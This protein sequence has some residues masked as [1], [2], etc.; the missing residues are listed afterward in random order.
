MWENNRQRNIIVNLVLAILLVVVVTVLTFGILK[1]NRETAEHDGQLSEIYVQQQQE[2]NEARQENLTAIQQAYEKDMATV[3]EYLPGIVCWGDNLTLGSSGNMSYPGALKTYLDTYFCDLYDFRSTLESVEGIGRVRWEDY[4]VDVPV[5]NMGAGKENTWTVL[6][7]SGAVPY[8]LSA[9]VTIPTD[10]EPVQVQF[11]SA[12]GAEVMPLT[13]GNAGVNN[14]T[15]NGVEGTLTIDAS[16]YYSTGNAYYF[17]RLTPGDEAYIPAGTELVTAASSQYRDY[18]H[19][20]WIGTYGTYTNAD[21]LV[22]QVKMLLSRQAKN[23]E[24][25]LVLGNCSVNGFSSDTYTMDAIDTAMMQAFGSQYINVRKYLCS[26]GM[27]DAGINPT[28]EDRTYISQ[29][30]VPPSFTNAPGSPELNGRAFAV[31]GKLVYNR[32]DSLG[33]FE[34]VYNELGIRETTKAILKEDP[35]YFDRMLKNTLN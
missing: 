29:N 17:T 26:D 19:I 23:P 31:I 28:S 24:R 1:V 13:G 18:I 7:R 2:Q 33:Y 12:Q 9:D 10:T 22:K 25:F 35:S 8:V 16:N 32:M 11:V 21:D 34:E 14:V 27:I 6:G 30:M 5:V 3:A 15:L 20:V 4:K